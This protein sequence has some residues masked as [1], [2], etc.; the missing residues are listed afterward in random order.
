MEDRR[1]ENQGRSDLRGLI[2]LL[3][4]LPALA[5]AVTPVR[6]VE[7]AAPELS[8]LSAS[9]PCAELVAA[10]QARQIPLEGIDSPREAGG[11]RE[12]DSFSMLATLFEAG[13]PRTQWLFHVTAS[14]SAA[15]ESARKARSPMVIYSGAGQKLEYES[16]PT[17]VSLR[18]LG[19][20]NAAGPAKKAEKAKERQTTFALDEGFL[21]LGLEIGRAHV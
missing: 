2:R 19:P 3:A 1:A 20:F 9:P 11:L 21:G 5:W 8:R 10:A 13:K 18:T 7:A 4:V 6:G 15:G 14:P 17:W 12:G 16:S